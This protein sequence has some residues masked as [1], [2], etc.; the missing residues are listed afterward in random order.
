M[1]GHDAPKPGR[2]W[3]GDPHDRADNRLLFLRTLSHAV[4]ANQAGSLRR[5]VVEL[6]RDLLPFWEE[7]ME[8]SARAV[9]DGMGGHDADERRRALSQLLLEWGLEC[10]RSREPP[11]WLLLT[12]SDTLSWWVTSN[13]RAQSPQ[14]ILNYQATRR[15]LEAQGLQKDQVERRLAT[16]WP[17]RH[18]VLSL[19][20]SST[21]MATLE[22]VRLG[23]KTVWRETWRAIPGEY[24]LRPQLR[25]RDGRARKRAR[26]PL[27]SRRKKRQ[28]A[29]LVGYQVEGLSLAQI[30]RGAG[31]SAPTVLENLRRWARVFDLHLRSSTGP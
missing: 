26:I 22:L 11:G 8:A 3:A 20:M 21:T 23:Q 14:F 24:P 10:R 17:E 28:I 1:S 18:G 4:P 16:L 13:K 31:R 2:P 7:S 6:L 5:T 29:D 9:P 27:D 15:R 25:R 12:L 19:S 30:A